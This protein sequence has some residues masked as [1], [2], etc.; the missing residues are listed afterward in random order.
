MSDEELIQACLQDELTPVQADALAR[1]MED[2]PAFRER[3]LGA[4]QVEGLLRA[5]Y[6]HEDLDAAM[7]RRTLGALASPEQERRTEQAV[8]ERIQGVRRQARAQARRRF[9]PPAVSPWRWA[10]PLAA[11]AAAL[12]VWRLWPDRGTADEASVAALRGTV[13]LLTGS[14]NLPVRS[15]RSIRIGQ[16]L[17]TGAGA[18]ARLRFADRTE[19]ALGGDTRLALLQT[20]GGKLLR[21][22]HG[23]LKAR[24]AAQPVGAPLVLRT[25]QADLTVVGTE[26][27]L[28]VEDGTC[29]LEVVEGTVRLA[30]ARGDASVDVRGGEYAE[31]RGTPDELVHGK[32]IRPQDAVVGPMPDRRIDETSVAWFVSPEGS[33][34]NDGRSRR[35]PFATLQKAAD[36]VQPGETVLALRGVYPEGFWIRKE[37]R[38]DAW[39][40]FL[41]EAGAEIRGSEVRR[42]FVRE[43]G[44]RPVYSI[45]R[46][47]LLPHWQQPGIDLRNRPEQVLVNGTF[48][49][50]VPDRA[51]LKP[52]NVFYV[53]D[54]EKKLYVCLR[55]GRDPNRETTEVTLRTHAISIG[56]PPNTNWWPEPET[57]EKNRAAYVRVDGFRIRH[58]GN[59]SRHAA[60]QIRGLCHDVLIE[61]CDV[62]QANYFGISIHGVTRCSA[63]TGQWFHHR[64]RRVTIRHCIFSNNGAQGIGGSGFDDGVIEYNLL[65]GNNYKG[66]SIWNE[67]GAMKL[68]DCSRFV[69]RGNVARRNEN[70]GFWFDGAMTGGL[71]ENNLVYGSLVAGI[72]NEATP[73]P[74]RIHE[75]GQESYREKI[76]TAAEARATNRPGT[77]I[78]NNVI[79]ATRTPLGDGL[80]VSHSSE[81]L[82]EN[83]IVAFNQGGGIV[84][85]GSATR[86]GT[87]GFHNNRA[88]ANICLANAWHAAVTRDEDDPTGRC[89]GNR[90][91]DN[92]F[93]QAKSERPFRIG[94]APATPE[95]FAAL[96]P[97]ANNR[98]ENQRI[99]KDPER[100]D[101]TLVDEEL[102]GKI[103]FDPEAL[104][105][106][107]S[108]FRI[109][110][111]TP[112]RED[113]AA[114]EAAA[115][116]RPA[117]LDFGEVFRLPFDGDVDALGSR[118]EIE[119]R[120]IHPVA[121]DAGLFVEGRK[122]K[123]LVVAREGKE[124]ERIDAHG[125]H[126][127]EPADFAHGPTGTVS[128]WLLADDWRT[129]TTGL[130]ENDYRR[131]M[132]PFESRSVNVRFHCRPENGGRLLL[133]LDTP[134]CGGRE[135]LTDLVTPGQWFNLTATWGPVPG[136]AGKIR[137]TVYV[138]GKP[139]G[140]PRSSNAPKPAP[141]QR[142]RIG[143][144]ANGGQPWFG[145]MDEFRVWNRSLSAGEI[146]AVAAGK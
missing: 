65:D 57:G 87:N 58:I 36:V 117:A 134:G 104:R 59:F 109:E 62:Q 120:G 53:D 8:L 101:F 113:E 21:L 15:E 37:G 146:A 31:T 123:A 127:A 39:I 93:L 125:F 105:L 94:G 67:G 139:L 95:A 26:F 83:N 90:M 10:L 129:R 112:G 49:Q 2:D 51:M 32:W 52:R 71:V 103:G 23:R 75:A 60:I 100:W 122:G 45:P 24:V 17:R 48:L 63:K 85:A 5:H 135:D 77:R 145:A 111:D 25:Q 84:F 44:E 141:G 89:F 124:G 130:P 68:S 140:T 78:R 69:V 72:L 88:R 99:F 28:R 19:L 81:T 126:C 110:P 133:D 91:R 79:L 14:G 1:K 64:P 34:R 41:A 20:S 143:R 38:P 132:W 137:R 142:I 96:E 128:L 12:L 6:A 119:A 4:A 70:R 61:N 74:E 92:L 131:T 108:G 47:E 30:T 102:A 22:E 66:V 138:D 27:A 86:Q 98:V 106:D 50:Q 76:L 11:A 43:P 118:G 3:L 33:D 121:F 46:P 29:R 136:Q 40:A 116:P 114:A 97:D 55:D 56:G 18:A 42:D 144:P 16:T 9:R 35:T 82:V 107:W 7:E 73:A 80:T 54:R 13:E 115:S